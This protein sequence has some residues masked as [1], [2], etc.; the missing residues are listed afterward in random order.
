MG[1]CRFA[2]PVDGTAKLTCSAFLR[3]YYP[4]EIHVAPLSN[5]PIIRDLVVDID[6]FMTKL[7]EIKPYIIREDLATAPI[8]AGQEFRQLPEQVDDYHQFSMCINCM[9]CYAACPV[10]GLTEQRFLGPAA[11]AL[12][13]RYNQDSRDHG[14]NE[15]MSFVAS[16]E[17]LWE[18]TAVG[19]CT[20]VCPKGVDPQAAIQREKLATTTDFWQSMVLP[21]RS[22]R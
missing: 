5:F 14:R 6:D 16:S 12:A 8:G 20:V 21:W 11:I 4:R 22:K 15:R 17:G 3:D 2:G 13:H 1:R 7:C 10:Y 19:E 18:C 9:L